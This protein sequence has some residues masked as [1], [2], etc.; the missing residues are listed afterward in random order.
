[1]I[2]SLFK[3]M[4]F[5]YAYPPKKVR[6]PYILRNINQKKFLCKHEIVDIGIFDLVK[7]KQPHN[8]KKINKWKHLNPNGWKVVPDCPDLQREFNIKVDWDNVEYSKE[9]LLKLFNPEDKTHLPV[10]QTHYADLNSIT[11][12]CKWFIKE[13]SSEQEKIGI[14]TICRLN[15]KMIATKAMKIVRQYFPQSFIHVFGLRLGHL[16]GVKNIINSFDSSAWT[17]PRNSGHSC[18]TQKERIEYFNNYL[19]IVQE[20]IKNKSTNLLSYIND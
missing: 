17:F 11:E 19:K 15:N 3:I 20:R 6:Y 18:K 13:F 2:R 8:Q 5:F 12:Y 16:Y 10:I 14:G 9:L 1:M 7:K 4:V